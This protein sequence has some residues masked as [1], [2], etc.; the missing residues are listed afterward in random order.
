MKLEPNTL[1]NSSKVIFLA[2][3]CSCDLE[4]SQKVNLY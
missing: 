1:I 4:I 2:A 3:S